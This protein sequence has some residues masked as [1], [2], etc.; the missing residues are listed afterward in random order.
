M[1]SN[2][3]ANGLFFHPFLTRLA[4]HEELKVACLPFVTG[5]NL[6]C[7]H[8]H[9]HHRAEADEAVRVEAQAVEG[10]AVRAPGGVVGITHISLCLGLEVQGLLLFDLA[11]HHNLEAVLLYV[12]LPY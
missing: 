7:N 10:A 5:N 11:W 8:R 2:N 4:F 6:V 3:V 12:S 1:V 9:L